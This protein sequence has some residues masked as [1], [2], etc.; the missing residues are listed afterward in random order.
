MAVLASRLPGIRFEAPPAPLDEVLPRMDIA[1]FAG[2]ASSGPVHVPV[3]VDSVAAFERVFGG[4]APLAW[5][6]GVGQIQY[7]HLARAV[8]AYFRGGG[9]RCWVVRVADAPVFNYFPLAGMVRLSAGQLAPA[10]ARSRAAGRWSDAT[11]VAPAVVP[12]PVEIERLVRA[13]D[14]VVLGI[15]SSAENDIVAGDVLRIEVGTRYVLFV[16]VDKCA[17]VEPSV[18]SNRL[19]LNAEG[20]ATWFRT[21]V[22]SPAPAAPG[23]AI[24]FTARRE[25]AGVNEDFQETPVPVLTDVS[26]WGLAGPRGAVELEFRLPIELAPLPGMIV[27]A[28]A[29]SE[30]LWMA[31]TDVGV[32]SGHAGATPRLH[33]RGRGLWRMTAPPAGSIPSIR[34]AERLSLE[35]WVDEAGGEVQ[36]IQG[37]GLAPSHP[38]FWADLRIDDARYGPPPGPTV[39]RRPLWD[40]A[41]F[42]VAG[43]GTA[44]AVLLPIDVAIGPDRYLGAMRQPRTALERD[45]LATFSPLLFLDRDLAT[46][47]AT[48]VADTAAHIVYTQPVPR[49]LTGIHAAFD[50]EEATIIA[51]PDAVQPGWRPVSNQAPLPPHRSTPVARPAW[52]SFIRCATRVV[53]PPKWA[54]TFQ[55]RGAFRFDTGTFTLEWRG[56]VGADFVVEE[57]RARDWS[58]SAPLYEGRASTLNLYNRQRGTYYYRVRAVLR[59]NPSNWSRGLTVSVGGSS[60]WHVRDGGSYSSD[61]LLAVHAGLMRMAAARGDMLA[62]LG[63][64]SH[65][66]AGDALAHIDTLK[67]RTL[68][69]GEAHAFSYGALYHPWPAV[70]DRSRQDA[71]TST[72]PD[73]L[74]A[75]LI[76]R[77]TLERGAWIAP[78][79]EPLPDVLALAPPVQRDDH[80]PLM[81]A[82]LNLIVQQPRGFVPLTASTLSDDDDLVPI[83]VRRLMSLLRRL[84]LREGATYV[85]EPNDGPF[86]RAVQRGFEGMLTR[87]FERGAFAGATAS[88]A[89]QVVT[90]ASVNTPQSVDAGRFI[91]E[92]RVA[93]SRPMTF[94]TVRLVQSADRTTVV[95]GR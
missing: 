78:A 35:L 39:P 62:V 50:I 64:P 37:L 2:F 53:K 51:A 67:T 24:V 75:G 40:S 20:A 81:N 92:L 65:Y 23:T 13:N 59:G 22:P 87:M 36:R 5:D 7:A 71:P 72:P 38:R 33:V 41:P 46:A 86:Q 90:S 69:G 11:R 73:G 70:R 10:Y 26:E 28:T 88:T 27:S 47:L 93:P 74:A 44:D 56:P 49:P 21:T 9:I 83:G 48:S 60:E 15:V 3:A 43:A 17:R 29:G 77:R 31:V 25:A 6:P 84:A 91:V 58:D 34:R 45:G 57:A 82:G 61:T 66:R 18:S 52:G 63:L 32:R 42:P 94:L 55:Q 54:A 89:F 85:F 14:R 30:Q 8:R 79:N 4:D 19:R 1:V 16:T 95:E 12:T 76:A 68:R 80:L